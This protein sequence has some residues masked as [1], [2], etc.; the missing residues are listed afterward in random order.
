MSRPDDR[1]LAV[2]SGYTAP[3]KLR[4][5]LA[6]AD[7]P[8]VCAGQI[9]RARIDGTSLTVLIVSDF[10]AGS[11]D[12]VVATPGEAPPAGSTIEHRRIATDVF[13][14]LTL[15]PSVQGNLHHRVL[16]V[17]VELSTTSTALAHDLRSTSRAVVVNE[18]PLDPGTE[19]VAELRDDLARL[20][21]APVVPRRTKDAVRHVLRLPGTVREQLEQ[22]IEHLGVNQHEAMDLHRGRRTL[23]AEQARVLEIANGL[24]PGTLTSSAGVDPDL[25]LEIEHPRWREATR[26]RAAH[27]GQDEVAARI[28]LAAEAYALAARES[29]E[30]PDW[31]QRIALLVAG[32]L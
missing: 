22:L 29:T 2:L 1:L 21:A 28:S 17:M 23:N 7:R 8:D 16:D 18:D 14:S 27:T 24:E 11:G 20:Q 12:V 32:E 9:W 13:R 19:L 3:E 4:E 30:Q 5:A 25:A 10:A 26:R 6:A 15:W 31:H